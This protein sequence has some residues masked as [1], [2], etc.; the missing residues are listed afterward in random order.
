L[1]SLSLFSLSLSTVELVTHAHGGSIPSQIPNGKSNMST[2]EYIT[3]CYQLI[4]AGNIDEETL[5]STYSDA[6]YSKSKDSI[7]E[8]LE[9]NEIGLVDLTYAVIKLG[10]CLEE[11]WDYM[12]AFVSFFE[13]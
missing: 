4:Q 12:R 6:I 8:R 13:L 9:G 1:T 5:R 11:A 3:Q 2:E 10:M 7:Q